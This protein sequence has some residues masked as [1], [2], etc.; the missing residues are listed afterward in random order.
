MAPE[1][2]L[3]QQYTFS[4]DIFSFGILLFEMLYDKHPLSDIVGWF[5]LYPP[6][7]D[8]LKPGSYEKM[9]RIVQGNWLAFP[10]TRPPACAEM[11]RKCCRKD[12][13]ARPTARDAL[14]QFGQCPTLKVLQL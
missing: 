2:L 6:Y 7:A 3:L 1:V 10:N 8:N 4:A 14:Q 12:P 5:V 9:T 13:Q 11:I